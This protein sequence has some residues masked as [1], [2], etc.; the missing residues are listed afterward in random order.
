M[1]TVLLD[2]RSHG[3]RTP[4]QYA[5]GPGFSS[6]NCKPLKVSRTEILTS[7]GIFLPSMKVVGS[8]FN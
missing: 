4:T 6:L 1:A 8:G 3:G 2:F 7:D 5:Q